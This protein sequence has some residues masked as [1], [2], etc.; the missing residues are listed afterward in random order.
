[1]ELH[2]ANHELN[3]SNVELQASLEMI[4]EQ[5]LQIEAK[6]RHISDSIDYSKNLQDALLCSTEEIAKYGFEVGLFYE[7]KDVLSG[8]FYWFG[9]R[10]DYVYLAVAD[11]TG[12]G[13]PGAM[14]S[15]TGHNL[16]NK[17]IYEHKFTDVG[18]ILTQLHVE[19]KA[20]LYAEETGTEDGMDIQLICLDKRSRSLNYAG[21]KNPLYYTNGGDELVKISADRF[22]IGGTQRIK[23]PV[24]T[25][26]SLP[27][28]WKNVFLFTD[29]YQD[30]FS[31]GNRKFM[32][33]NF[34]EL[35]HDVVDR[36]PKEQAVKLK[37]VFREWKGSS[38]QTDDVLV[39]CLKNHDC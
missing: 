8:D 9:R 3:E 31:E 12:H 36:S 11:C 38:I 30:Q 27:K 5:K 15:I 21:A 22:S 23:A 7:P 26:H 32:V 28:D 25:K 35:L 33:R 1:M 13:V 10:G 2:E 18:V 19:L 16:L 4:H 34:K 14:L 20:I 6:Q 17:I 29:G 37:K 39:M 24:F